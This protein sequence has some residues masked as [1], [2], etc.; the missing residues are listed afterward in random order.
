MS[1]PQT[2]VMVAVVVSRRNVFD[3]APFRASGTRLHVGLQRSFLSLFRRLRQ[4]L[5]HVYYAKMY[6]PNC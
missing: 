4:L 1:P 3:D 6:F 2:S 5:T